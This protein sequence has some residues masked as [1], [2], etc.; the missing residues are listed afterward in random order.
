MYTQQREEIIYRAIYFWVL[1]T[2]KQF[3]G[4]SR[5]FLHGFAITQV[6]AAGFS[7][8]GRHYDTVWRRLIAK[9]L[10]LKSIIVIYTKT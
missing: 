10:N 9:L 8:C 6:M 1:D 2:A 4:D 7:D 3:A 5:G